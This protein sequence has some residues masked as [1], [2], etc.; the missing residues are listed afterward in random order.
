VPNLVL[1]G[2]HWGDEGKGRFVDLLTSRADLVVRFQG[3]PNAGHTL[4]VD[5]EELILH[6]VPSGI[7]H[8]HV[9]CVIGNGVVVDPHLL[10]GELEEL[11]AGGHEV[12]PERLRVSDRAIAILPYHR[13]RD[14]AS[15]AK[16]G[17]RKIGTTGRGIGP[18]YEDKAGRRAVRMGDLLA[19][20][21]L[22]DVLGDAGELQVLDQALQWGRQLAPFITDTVGLIH[23]RMAAGGAVLFEGAQG[24]MLDLDHGTYPYVT[25]SNTVAGGACSGAGVGPTAIDGVLG[26]VKAYTTRVGEGPFPTEL[27][28][29]VAETLAKRGGEVGATTGRA[30]RCGW[31]DAVILRRAVQLNGITGLAVTKM[32]VLSGL[33][34]LRVATAYELDSERIGAPPAGAAD[35]ARC[36]PVYEELAGWSEDIGGVRRFEDLPANAQAYLERLEELA[37]VPVQLVS[38]GP[39]RERVIVREDPFVALGT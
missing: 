4:V 2:C 6:L 11:R 16:R 33:D 14:G 30:R 25:S 26:I 20:D 35:L 1:I 23:E 34:T 12:G 29:D 8:E 36:T 21:R 10:L 32:D 17:N 28:D 5:G 37:G 3:G 9:T 24:T 31:L 39:Q 13:T 38:V 27:F 7:L 19:P 18:A 15:E 22:A